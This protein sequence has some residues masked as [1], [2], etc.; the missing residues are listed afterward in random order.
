MTKAESNKEYYNRNKESI[1]IKNKEYREK[2]KEIITKRKKLYRDTHKSSIAE[3]SKIYQRDNR[4]YLKIYIKAYQEKH[5]ERLSAYYKTYNKE[6]EESKTLYRILNKEKTA[7]R[8]KSEYDSNKEKHALRS[9]NYRLANLS[10]MNVN[11]QNRKARARKLPHTL[12]ME[13]WDNTQKYFDHKC[14][15]CGE[16]N[17]LA[18]D[19]FYP[20]NH[21]GEFTISNIICACKRCNSSKGPKLYSEWYHKQTYY[22]KDRERKIFEYLKYKNNIQQLYFA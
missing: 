2:N 10:K 8:R 9:K 19:H 18:Q 6:N 3:H 22:N 4:E 14:A 21:G 13:Q 20:L 12:T 16:G 7:I 1:A 17:P 5:R 15:Y 11:V